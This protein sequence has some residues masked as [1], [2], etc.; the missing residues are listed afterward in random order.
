M[1]TPGLI[2]AADDFKVVQYWNGVANK[3]KKVTMAVRTNAEIEE[4]IWINLDADE[5]YRLVLLSLI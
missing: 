3:N 4:C 1:V 5:E 2:L